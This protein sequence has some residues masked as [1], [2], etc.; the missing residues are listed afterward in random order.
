LAYDEP[1]KRFLVASMRTGEVLSVN[2][3]GATSIFAAPS[4]DNG[5]YAVTSIVIDAP[6]NILYVASSALPSFKG[7]DNTQKGLGNISQFDLR[8]GK[9]IKKTAIPF[10]GQF[11]V[12]SSLS[13]ARSGEVYAADVATN[14]VYQ[15]R[16]NTITRLF[17]SD[18][19]VSIRT[20][21][22][23]ANHKTLFISDHSKGLFAANLEKNEIRQLQGKGHN[24]GGI[25]GIYTYFD[26]VLAI[27]NST[28]PKRIM[29]VSVNP[30][31][32]IGMRPLEANKADL[33]MPTTGTLVNHK[34]YV[35][36]NSQRDL[37]DANGKIVEGKPMRRKI[38]VIDPNFGADKTV[39]AS[40]ALQKK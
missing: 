3:S 27:Q 39:P 23:S 29:R 26:Q 7:F 13:V 25:D 1:R 22:V 30:D 10:D 37:Y 18:E 15:M 14:S 33:V 34:L 38:Y 28:T 12:F 24:L 5:L 21:S 40:P 20:V 8:S 6:R 32:S 36:A 31:G 4:A 17:G 19:F 11:H 2:P 35:I 9:L 16:N